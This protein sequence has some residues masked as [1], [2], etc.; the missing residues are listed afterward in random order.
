[1]FGKTYGTK[2]LIHGLALMMR[3]GT[4]YQLPKCFKMQHKY[5]RNQI[6]ISLKYSS[7]ICVLFSFQL[8]FLFFILNYIHLSVISLPFWK[9]SACFL[10]LSH[11]YLIHYMASSVLVCKQNLQFFKFLIQILHACV[12]ARVQQPYKL[13][14]GF[15][16]TSVTL[17][18]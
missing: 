4:F 16:L 18:K 10:A 8:T 1:M 5:L 3:Q 15:D 17:E 11:I 13:L 14:L 2:L 7:L 9:L 6:L 12:F